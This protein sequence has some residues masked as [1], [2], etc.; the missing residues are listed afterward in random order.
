MGEHMK[1]HLSVMSFFYAA[2]ISI[3]LFLLTGCGDKNQPTQAVLYPELERIFYRTVTVDSLN[4][5]QTNQSGNRTIY[6]VSGAVNLNQTLYRP[7]VV[8]TADKIVV[9]PH[10][11]KGTQYPFTASLTAV[12]NT[13]V[14]WQLSFANIITKL[15]ITPDLL[16]GNA[17]ESDDKYLI[18][19]NSNFK[20]Q[21]DV[22]ADNILENNRKIPQYKA[23]ISE[24]LAKQVELNKL[25]QQYQIEQQNNAQQERD[26][27]TLWFDT[28]NANNPRQAIL[29]YWQKIKLDELKKLDTSSI[30]LLPRE[31]QNIRSKLVRGIKDNSI[32]KSDGTTWSIAEI[33]I[34]IEKLTIQYKNAKDQLFDSNDKQ[35]DE[36]LAKWQHEI[37]LRKQ[38]V[39][40][41]LQLISEKYQPLIQKSQQA[42][43]DAK[44]KQ[45]SLEGIVRQFT[46]QSDQFA[47]GKAI[48][49]QSNLL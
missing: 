26:A 38:A 27:Y 2:I 44:A 18:T 49:Q 37:D 28:Y 15:H 33:D 13:D 47:K 20:K 23:E 29:T 32:I 42:L 40:Q 34:E 10:Y 5:K 25:I 35:R 17:I 1:Q 19:D 11:K 6:D 31:Y 39:E 48:L 7:I 9:T 12:G 30:A 16:L 41:K 4:L 8:L 3:T 24:L 36:V 46:A 43:Q 14:G 45:I 22:I 21:I